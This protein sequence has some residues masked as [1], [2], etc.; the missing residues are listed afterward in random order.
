MKKT[1]LVSLLLSVVGCGQKIDFNGSA[2]NSKPL[3]C[4]PGTTTVARPTKVLFL[5]DQ[6]GSNVTGPTEHP[7]E[8]SDSLK[9]FRFGAINEFFTQ[10][11]SKINLG[12]GFLSFHED[13][14][15]GLIL[16]GGLPAF[17]NSSAMSSALQTFSGSTDVGATPYRAAI[18]AAAQMIARDIAAAPNVHALYRLAFLTDGYPSDYC[19]DT[20]K[21]Y[22]P[23]ET[24]EV[25]MMSDLQA[26]INLAPNSIKLS[27]IYYGWPDSSATTRLQNMARAGGGQFVDASSSKSIHLD[28]VL[29]VP[30]SCP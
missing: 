16:S 6:S 9:S 20:S 7:G 14:A 11:S 13:V 22:C 24:N 15:N 19:L 10:H 27:T 28:D 1:L 21:T 2:E 5:V 18:Q 30:V 8:A 3:S 12:W 23:G 4:T 25:Q 26:L 17:S 29:E